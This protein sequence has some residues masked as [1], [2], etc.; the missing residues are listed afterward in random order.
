MRIFC[1]QG[2]LRGIAAYDFIY[3][4]NTHEKKKVRKPAAVYPIS[5]Y[6]LTH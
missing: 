6:S 1:L 2:L 5:L 4:K 3:L